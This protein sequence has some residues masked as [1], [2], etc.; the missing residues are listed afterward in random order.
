MPVVSTE[1]KNKYYPD[2]FI[3]GFT[4]L[5]VQV[6]LLREFLMVFYG[7]ELVIGV[8][9]SLWMLL[10][11]AGAWAGRYFNG[12]VNYP[13]LI[14]L[15]LLIICVYPL[16]ASF[17][18]EF[19]RND[20]FE[21]G[22]MISFFEIIFFS[23]LILLPLCFAGG[24]TFVLINA[25]KDNGNG[26]AQKVY[27]IESLGSMAG[28]MVISILFIY[29]LNIDNFKSLEYIM[30][31][32]FIYFGIIDFRRRR[33]FQSL[34]FLL[35]AIGIMHLTYTYDIEKVA[36]QALF[37]GQELILTEETPYGNLTITK[38]QNQLN[39]YENGVLLFSTDNDVQRE[40]DV[41]YAMLQRPGAKHVLLIGG[42]LTGTTYE[43]LKYPSVEQ[44]D[45]LE[46]NRDIINLTGE[47]IDFLNNEKIHYHAVDPL[48]FVKNTDTK[49]D[50]VIINQ[51]PPSSAQ[52]NRFFTVD[53][54]HRLK[55]IIKEKGILATR[56][57][58]SANYL[59]DEE[60]EL[61]SSIYNGLRNE[62]RNILILPG[63][64][65]YYLASD[66][67]LSSNYSELLSVTELENK[68]VNSFYINSDLLNFR[69]S[70]LL[71]SFDRDA[72]LN[73]DF[74]P[75]VYLIYLKYWLSY[76]GARFWI[77]PFIC[78]TL[79]LVFFIFAKPPST[80]MFTSGLTGAAVEVVLIISFQVI[81]GNV[82]LFLGVF[83]T[84]FMAGLA[85]GGW[86]SSFCK[87]KN[88][89]KRALF[90]QFFTGIYI[91]LI[92]VTLFY[93]KDYSGTLL[94]QLTFFLMIIVVSMFVGLQYGVSISKRKEEIRKSVSSVYA[95][96]LAGAAV[97]SLLAVIW[98]IPLYGI[99]VSLLILAG[100]H[101]LT[102]F[103]LLLKGNLKYF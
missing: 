36:R 3:L 55:S 75:T 5:G 7:N 6:I 48:I 35:A 70:Q 53:F 90:I 97:G 98:L 87:K 29:Y 73:K 60:I 11:G 76:F 1:N 24:M 49:Y 80:V 58:S 94:I 14:R 32:N 72:P 57:S 67:S 78:I 16:S 52:L 38:T 59:S 4:L 66:D 54:Y 51:P 18:L 28:G 9:L 26:H 44:L 31:I 71:S 81:F 23:F 68:Y 8:L 61:Q 69:S 34:V 85:A 88:W 41:H 103:I 93:L 56:I 25:S 12:K 83:I 79:M 22:R 77:L 50:V 92:A 96:D 101:F 20:I 91:L 39:F 64:H 17:G 62:F 63:S 84:V 30:L 21:T 99:Y 33:P 100:L 86:L 42:G 10:S 45:Y 13:V 2:A 46:N 65:N 89:N 27:S 47:H 19:Y 95:S 74:K 43:I 102:L 15:L 37:P 82:Y 40:E